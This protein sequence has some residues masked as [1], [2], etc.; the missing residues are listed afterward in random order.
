MNRKY[1]GPLSNVAFDCNLRHYAE[2]QREHGDVVGLALAGERVVLISDP[3]VAADVMIERPE[4]FVKE[5]TAFFPGS[6]LAGQGPYLFTV[7]HCVFS[8]LLNLSRY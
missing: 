6:S 4:F 1:A 2:V 3:S 8:P 5:G 7:V